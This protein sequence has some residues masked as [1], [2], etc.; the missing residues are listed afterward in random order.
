M[1]A[2]A[3]SPALDFAAARFHMVESQLR[4]NKVRDERILDVMGRL[5]REM[6]VPPALAGIA[7]IDEELQAA[8]GRYLLEPMVL[9]RLLQEAGI[10]AEDRVLDIGPVTG[11]STV[12]I[13]SLAKQ[14]I[15]AECDIS[16]QKKTIDNLDSLRIPN[17]EVWLGPLP[18]G[19]AETAPYNVIFFNGSIETLPEAILNQLAEGGRLVTILRQY[20]PAQAAH[21]GEARLYE[22]IHGSVSHRALFDAHARLIPGF[23]AQ[24]RFA[25]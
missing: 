18:E 15:A 24:R 17:A 3:K 19:C 4:P 11:Y 9:A 7:Y 23:E 1:T 20:G 10:K 5:P 16:L 21:K 2:I 13:A 12:I 8:P 25:F 6:F 14:V 22:R